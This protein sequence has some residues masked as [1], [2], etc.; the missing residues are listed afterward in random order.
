MN[1]PG[2]S[3]LKVRLGLEDRSLDCEFLKNGVEVNHGTLP[4]A[5]G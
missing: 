4:A 5:L 3:V 2:E 1:S